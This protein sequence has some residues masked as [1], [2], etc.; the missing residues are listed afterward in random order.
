MAYGHIHTYHLPSPQ[1]KIQ[2]ISE[3]N[4]RVSELRLENE[5]QLRLKDMTY[6]DKIRQLTERAEQDI[7]ALNNTI[8]VREKWL[9]G[10]QYGTG[11]S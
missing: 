9:D 11:H 5:Y 6:A 2:L 8:E 4:T 10:V 7:Q 1:E 3:L